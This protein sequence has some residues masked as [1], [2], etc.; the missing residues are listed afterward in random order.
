MNQKEQ[1]RV[2][3]LNRVETKQIGVV[4]AAVLLNISERQAWRL[5]SAYRKSGAAG[6]AHGN[7]ERKPVNV[8]SDELKR[9][10][11]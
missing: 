10:V 8:L 1:T 6:L 4:Q 5:L 7:R 2:I 9:E 11:I 3:V